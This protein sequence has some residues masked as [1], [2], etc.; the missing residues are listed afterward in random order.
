MNG[1]WSHVAGFLRTI[2]EKV[3][4]DSFSWAHVF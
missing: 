4:L 3:V 2:F 1:R